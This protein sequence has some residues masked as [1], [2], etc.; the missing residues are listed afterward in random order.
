[1]N[2]VRTTSVNARDLLDAVRG[3]LARRW[4]DAD[5]NDDSH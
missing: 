1:M 5:G 3:D 4:C 2:A